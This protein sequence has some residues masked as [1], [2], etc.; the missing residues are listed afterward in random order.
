M[1]VDEYVW[2]GQERYARLDVLSQEGA[3]GPL[4]LIS[5]ILEF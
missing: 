2:T 4:S 5:G 1:R 3:S